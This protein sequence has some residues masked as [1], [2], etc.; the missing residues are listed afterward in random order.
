MPEGDCLALVFDEDVPFSM[1][2]LEERLW[3]VEEALGARESV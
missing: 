1:K 3:E 2:S